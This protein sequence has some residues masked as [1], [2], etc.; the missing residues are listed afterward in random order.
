M[1]V[2]RVAHPL[3]EVGDEPRLADP[4]RAEQREESARAI[5]DRVL[6]VA[7]EPLALPLTSD[8]RR[9]QMASDRL[10]VR[11]H[12][13]KSERLHGLSLSLERERLDRLDTDGISNEDARLGADEDLAGA[14]RLLEPRSDVDRVAGDERLAL[15]ADD[16]LARVDADPRLQVVL[17]DRSAHLRRGANRAERVVLVRSRNAEDRHHRVADELL[18]GT[19]VAFDDPPEV[20]EV[21]AHARAQCL[22]VGRL[23]EGSRAHEVT[24][25]N[26]DDLSLLGLDRGQRGAACAAEAGVVGVLA[27]TAR[28]GRH[29]AES[30]SERA[31]A[32]RPRHRRRARR[33]PGGR[34]GRRLARGPKPSPPQPRP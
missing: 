5:G 21:A 1:D 13:E 7:P 9:L 4:R 11:D 28:A 16:D 14:G 22:R 15:A 23:P 8:Q 27:P 20:F 25:E 34:S 17:G 19:A 10:R 12:V 6:V 26:R 31:G 3:E 24:E 32:R 33:P 29:V 18:D 30:T 2:G